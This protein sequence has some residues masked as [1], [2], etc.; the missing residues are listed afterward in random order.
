MQQRILADGK[1]ASNNPPLQLGGVSYMAS[2]AL[3][4]AAIASGDVVQNPTRQISR[5]ATVVATSVADKTSG[6]PLPLVQ[7]T[8]TASSR[9]TVRQLTRLRRG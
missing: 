4:Y 7:L 9:A 1:S 8:V 2:L 3:I 6:T 5:T